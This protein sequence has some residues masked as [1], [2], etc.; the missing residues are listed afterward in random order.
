[1]NWTP[2]WYDGPG[3]YKA[4]WNSD[5][6]TGQQPSGDCVF[7]FYDFRKKHFKV[8]LYTHGTSEYNRVHGQWG[9]ENTIRWAKKTDMKW[10]DYLIPD[11]LPEN[12]DTYFTLSELNLLFDRLLYNH[13]HDRSVHNFSDEDVERIK[14]MWEH[15]PNIDKVYVD[16]EVCRELR[17]AYFEE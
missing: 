8:Y 4:D 10:V 11:E 16:S 9:V 13:N 5:N 12:P 15:L 3:I 6:R 1:M 17:K 2:N 14:R 7:A